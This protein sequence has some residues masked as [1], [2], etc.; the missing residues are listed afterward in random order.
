MTDGAARYLEGMETGWMQSLEGLE[1]HLIKP[2]R[3]GLAT[4]EASDEYDG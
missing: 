3:N 4:K 2:Q 1:S